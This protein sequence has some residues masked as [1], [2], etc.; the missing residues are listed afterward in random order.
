M[1]DL[2]PPLPPLD[3]LVTSG[4]KIYQGDEIR[5]RQVDARP[6]ELDIWCED[7]PAPSDRHIAV[8]QLIGGDRMFGASVCGGG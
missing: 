6:G 4:S 5:S 8:A 2:P 3:S 7:V 1:G